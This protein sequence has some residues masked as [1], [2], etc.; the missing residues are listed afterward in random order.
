MCDVVGAWY[1][2]R[3]WERGNGG[4]IS[5]FGMLRVNEWL[6]SSGVIAGVGTWMVVSSWKGDLTGTNVQAM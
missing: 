5:L 3:D 6:P 2:E 4:R 1:G